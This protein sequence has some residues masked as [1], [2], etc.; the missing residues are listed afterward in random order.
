[1]L[2]GRHNYPALDAAALAYDPLDQRPKIRVKEYVSILSM[3][4]DVNNLLRE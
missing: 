2:A 3:I 1:V 4:D